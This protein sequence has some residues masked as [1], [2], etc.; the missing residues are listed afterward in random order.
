VSDEDERKK[1]LERDYPEPEGLGYLSPSSIRT[2]GI[3][4]ND[5]LLAKDLMATQTHYGQQDREVGQDQTPADAARHA[6]LGYTFMQEA[7]PYAQD[8]PDRRE[9]GYP[10]QAFIS[11]MAF[12]QNPDQEDYRLSGGQI[13]DREIQYRRNLQDLGYDVESKPFFE[14]Y[15]PFRSHRSS[16]QTLDIHNNRIGQQI[17]YLAN[18][19]EEAQEIIDDLMKNVRIYGSLEELYQDP[20]GRFELAAMAE[21]VPMFDRPVQADSYRAV[22]PLTEQEKADLAAGVTPE[23]LEIQ[24]PSQ[25]DIENRGYR[26]GQAFERNVPI[27]NYGGETDLTRQLVAGRDDYAKLAE[28]AVDFLPP[29][30]ILKAPS[31]A[32]IMNVSREE[33]DAALEDETALRDLAV[34]QARAAAQAEYLY[35]AQRIINNAFPEARSEGLEPQALLPARSN[36]WWL[37]TSA[38]DYKNFIIDDLKSFGYAQLSY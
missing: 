5:Y 4:R 18:T 25:Y 2:G 33:L 23:E 34:R 35:E 32:A 7:A 19:R 22:R 15:S 17:A 20:P 1:R 24:I 31:Y 28:R 29:D 38:D 26:E 3:T 14:S 37:N 36:G 30:L 10:G 13:R 9:L 8:M 11:Q 21:G 16:T 27:V 6:M 12:H